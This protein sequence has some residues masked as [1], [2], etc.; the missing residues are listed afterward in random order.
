MA[1]LD[2]A[3]DLAEGR[4]RGVELAAGAP[5]ELRRLAIVLREE[6]GRAEGLVDDEIGVLRVLDEPLVRR[7]VAAEDQF[8]AG[9]LDDEADRAVAGVDGRDGA[10]PDAVFIVDDL[11]DRLVVEFHHVD[12]PGTGEILNARVW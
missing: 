11:V 3:H 8:H 4:P 7:G 12:L 10:D 2:L 1:R 6:L 5:G 9:I